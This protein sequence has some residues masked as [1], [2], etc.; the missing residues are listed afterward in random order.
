MY[1]SFFRQRSP[2]IAFFF[3]LFIFPSSMAYA[4]TSYTAPYDCTMN[5]DIALPV[6]TVP[7][8]GPNVQGQKTIAF[9]ASDMR[10]G[11]V[12]GVARGIV[13]AVQMLGWR[14]IVFDGN[15]SVLGQ[16]AALLKAV[17]IRPDGII[18]GGLDAQT[19]KK[20][21]A[22][23]KKN[24]IT[25][26][27]WHALD[28]A[29]ANNDLGLFTNI[30]T[31]AEEVARVAACFAINSTKGKANVVILTDT[32]FSIA[33]AKS[34]KLN[35]V[36]NSCASCKV[37]VTKD[38]PLAN[39]AEQISLVLEELVS[40]YGNEITHI[41]GI[42]DLYFD[43]AKLFFEKNKVKIKDVPK[44]ISAGDGSRTAYQRI[45]I[46]TYQVATVPEPLVLQ[47]WQA[48]DELNRAFNQQ[49][50]SG[51]SA[52][53]NVI[54]KKDLAQ[55]VIEDTYDPNNQYRRTYSNVWKKESL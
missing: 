24:N 54:T 31:D 15:G 53:V 2:L 12:D 55:H 28:T 44:M 17:S 30:T 45:R 25:V 21:L 8:N 4:E 13:E 33:R 3:T 34:N 40:Q 20:T 29:G 18:L 32:N 5:N 9:V 41:I 11:G 50:P 23:A 14:V 19:H 7:T 47:G 1:L 49:P 37:L 43:Y 38:V 42:N 51:F 35:K 48:I 27:G 10:N 22:V 6:W 39:T 52:P 26:V 46:G 36:I 16:A